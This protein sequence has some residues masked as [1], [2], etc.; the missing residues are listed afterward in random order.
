MRSAF[1]SECVKVHSQ[2]TTF[3]DILKSKYYN[4]FICDYPVL[5]IHI[6]KKLEEANDNSL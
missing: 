1:Q 3:R 5:G 6:I 4:R 2:S